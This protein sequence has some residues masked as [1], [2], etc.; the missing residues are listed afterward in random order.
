MALGLGKEQPRL[1]SKDVPYLIQKQKHDPIASKIL[2]RDDATY[3]NI[4]A[5]ID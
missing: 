2:F 1:H 5:E 3:L 4:S